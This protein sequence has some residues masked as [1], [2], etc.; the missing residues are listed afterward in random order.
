MKPPHNRQKQVESRNR[1]VKQ[2]NDEIRVY[3][4]TRYDV[5]KVR[6]EV[7]VDEIEARWGLSSITIEEILK[8]RGSYAAL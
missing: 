8:R 1:R 3:Y 6:K 5:D 2:R 7:I 4:R